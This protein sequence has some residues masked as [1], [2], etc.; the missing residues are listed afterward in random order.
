MQHL[1]DSVIADA[2]FTRAPASFRADL[3]NRSAVARQWRGVPDG[4]TAELEQ[5]L[6]FLQEAIVLA[7]ADR[8]LYLHNAGMTHLLRF[9]L[10]GSG[11]ELDTALE[12]MAEALDAAGRNP[13]LRPLALAGEAAVRNGR[14]RTRGARDDIE[15][16]VTLARAAVDEATAGSPRAPRYRGILSQALAYRYDA[17]GS[18]DDL[19]QAITLEP[20]GSPASGA[21]LRRRWF[22][23]HD[24][25]DLDQ[26]IDI[27]R[28]AVAGSA[29]GNRPA[30]LTN[31]G[32]TL[33]D[34]YHETG[35]VDDVRA[36]VEAHEQ[37]VLATAEGDWQLASRHNNAG[38][39]LLALYDQTDDLEDL[40]KAARE[41][42][43]AVA[44]TGPTA[45][46]RASRAYNLGNARLAL[47]ERTDSAS[48]AAAATDAYRAACQSGL[49]GGL[50]WALAS[51][52]AWATWAVD[53]AAWS[54]AADATSSGL[55]AV[56]QLFRRQL[57]RDEKETWLARAAGLP[58][59]AAVA[60]AT[61]G[62]G[63]DATV[64]FECGRAFLLS[65][66]I[67]RSRLDLAQLE[68]GGA[69]RP[70]TALP[71]SVT[72]SS[73]RLKGNAVLAKCPDDL[74]GA[75]EVRKSMR[76]A[77]RAYSWMSPP[78]RSRRWILS[79]GSEPTRC[80]RYPGVGGLRPSE[81]CGLCVL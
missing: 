61:A 52:Q 45:Q 50:E 66:A 33:L 4:S 73:L 25:R 64:A 80:R 23:L 29:A 28:K 57:A 56:D 49:V 5:G 42:E 58:S 37:S 74:A 44:M 3:L 2:A 78:R 53:R 75:R 9:E 48:D 77:A 8:A 36:A 12:L 69:T 60:L 21:L 81:R 38:N 24:R 27:L 39:S 31:L 17:L 30:N 62:R 59:L 16:A 20:E 11:S 13:T 32:N 40:E 7:P 63:K 35:D 76:H 19:Q 72:G 70:G 71:L 15:Q 14:F 1:W 34:R 6:E 43:L 46:E 47:W 67:E 68:T 22:A 18:I 41:Y 51:A 55:E 10:E 79:G 26:S 65:E 54:D